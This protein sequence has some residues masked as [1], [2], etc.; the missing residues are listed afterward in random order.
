MISERE[1][2]LNNILLGRTSEPLTPP[3]EN[4]EPRQ[5]EAYL[6]SRQIM[7]KMI[8]P[9]DTTVGPYSGYASK[10]IVLDPSTSVIAMVPTS[11]HVSGDRAVDYTVEGPRR[12]PLVVECRQNGQAT[13]HLEVGIFSS[14]INVRD[15]NPDGSVLATRNSSRAEELAPSDRELVDTV[16]P[17][18]CEATRAKESYQIQKTSR[19][20]ET[21]ATCYNNS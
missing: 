2:A 20:L 6:L 1:A 12:L 8:P 11:R 18:I 9:E 15:L 4:G 7:A 17:R 5:F 13:K 3:T 14:F 10:E 16:L 19:L 21:L